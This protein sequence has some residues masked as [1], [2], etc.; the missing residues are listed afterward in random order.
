MK[1]T[2]RNVS[3]QA[4]HDVRWLINANLEL[5]EKTLHKN[6]FNFSSKRSANINS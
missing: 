3:R 6:V 1:L 2:L 4:L 5:N